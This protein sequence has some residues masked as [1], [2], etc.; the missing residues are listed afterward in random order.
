MQAKLECLLHMPSLSP[1]ANK[2]LLL[3]CQ[4]CAGPAASPVGS[5]SPCYLPSGVLV[6]QSLLL[7]KLAACASMLTRPHAAA[8]APDS[9]I[10]SEY[11]YSYVTTY[12]QVLNPSQW[13]HSTQPCTHKRLSTWPAAL[14]ATA[15]TQSTTTHMTQLAQQP[16]RQPHW[17]QHRQQ[18]SRWQHLPK[19]RPRRLR[20]PQLPSIRS[21][22]P[23]RL[24]SRVTQ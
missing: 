4:L 9:S 6:G 12:R 2:L 11:Y 18:H 19:W 1:R 23:L 5:R 24:C 3:I 15:L 22:A 17:E 16:H 8:D 14:A 21:A 13:L 10:S 20:L 7:H